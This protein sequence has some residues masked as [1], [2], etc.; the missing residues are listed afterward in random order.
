MDKYI[1]GALLL[2]PG[3]I[4][5]RVASLLG[6]PEDKSSNKEY[7]IN[8]IVFGTLSNLLSV[9]IAVALGILPSDATMGEAASSFSVSSV[10]AYS[11]LS[12][13]SSVAVGAIWA[14]LLEPRALSAMNWLGA[15]HGL[16]PYY[17]G[18]LLSH[19]FEDGKDHFLIIEKDGEDI[20]VGFYESLD[21][22][23]SA[24]ALYEYPAYRE[25]L[26]AARAGKLSYLAKN[27]RTFYDASTGLL[28]YETEYPP[29]WA[30]RAE[31]QV[32]A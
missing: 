9:L 6:Q 8:Y 21:H 12:V 17:N 4:A 7:I 11:A 18:S 2:V 3:F 29:E 27:L 30:E 24:I 20:G 5:L 1:T 25:E 13:L 22:N 28:I 16:D 31:Q 15:K 32:D 19:M 23:T 26:K 14:C 10:I